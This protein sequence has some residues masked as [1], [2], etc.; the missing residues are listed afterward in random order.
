[1]AAG[2]FLFC[3]PGRC[4]TSTFSNNTAVAGAGIYLLG[5]VVTMTNCTLN[6][7]CETWDNLDALGGGGILVYGGDLTMANCTL[8]DN[9][10]SN[11]GGITNCGTLSVTSCTLSG[12]TAWFSGGGIYNYGDLAVTSTIVAGNQAPSQ[13]DI[14]GWSDTNPVGDYNLIGGNP[15]LAPLG[16][17]GGPTQTMALLPG[18]PAIG[19]GAPNGPATDQRGISRDST[20]DIGSFE[21][22]GLTITISSGN[23]QST[24]VNTAFSQP[25]VVTVSS[26]YGEPVSGGQVSFTAPASTTSASLTSSTVMIGSDGTAHVRATANAS[27]G[28]YSVSVSASGATTVPFNLTN[29]PVVIASTTTLPANA[30]TLT[31]SGN[32][33]DTNT[34]N[35]SVTFDNGVTGTV[36]GA[37]STHLTVSVSGLSSLPVARSCMPASP[38]TMSAAVSRSRWPRCAP[39]VTCQQRPICLRMLQPDH[40]RLRLRHQHG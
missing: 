7:N 36:T 19:N 9:S 21:S 30:T 8:S 34:A 40:H 18:S 11:G 1:M 32:G 3:A 10:A 2:S 22:Q 25:L 38:W 13:P 23:N 5:S 15:L 31:I 24:A 17:Y 16:W 14:F 29:I 33:F 39:V 27:L 37:T 12:N 6:D 28:S 35:D 26:A 20:P 4:S